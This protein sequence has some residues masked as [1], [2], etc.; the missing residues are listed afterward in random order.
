M[1]RKLLVF[2]VSLKDKVFRFALRFLNDYDDAQD[3]AQDVFEKLWAK[4]KSLEKYDNIEALSLKMTRDLC[5]NRLK[6]QKV[7]KEK[8]KN[9]ARNEKYLYYKANYDEK[10]ME[11]IAKQ[12]IN[13]L[14]E[15]QK[16]VIQLRD[17]EGLE[18]EE[19]SEILELNINAIRMN[20]S[21][22]RNKIREQLLKIMN[23][24]LY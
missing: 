14:P 18:F 21:R 2:S 22:A 4:R 1:S 5:L 19:I 16:M 12:L 8:L 10:E 17:V 15:K 20:L 6:H 24:G 9:M 23:Y 11:V 7:K 3:I 13:N